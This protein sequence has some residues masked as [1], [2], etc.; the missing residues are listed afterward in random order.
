[1]Q[2]IGATNCMALR[3]AQPAP[4]HL[5]PRLQKEPGQ[6]VRV[7]L[8][9]AAPQLQR[10]CAAAPHVDA[11]PLPERGVLQHRHVR[12]P[13][14][15]R[16]HQAAQV[17]GVGGGLRARGRARRGGDA[18]NGVASV[19]RHPQPQTIGGAPQITLVGVLERPGIG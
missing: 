14:C 16:E 7:L 4:A 8:V 9:V 11:L 15:E 18:V 3:V 5:L 10:L 17:L 1:M 2:R 19:R 12:G 13:A 6:Q